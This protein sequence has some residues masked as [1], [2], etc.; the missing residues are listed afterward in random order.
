M[1]RVV[2]YEEVLDE[3]DFE[4]AAA[5]WP[6]YRP[7]KVQESLEFYR[8]R[9]AHNPA[10][11]AQFARM[12]AVSGLVEAQIG[13][14]HML[15]DG[16]GVARDP[17]AAFRWFRIAARIGSAEANNMAGRCC[18]LGWGVGVD[19]A[20][21]ARY[22]RV[23]AAQSHA[24]AQYNLARLIVC[25]DGVPCDYRAALDLL[26]RS[27]RSGN[28]KSMNM[29]GRFREEGWAAAVKLK[30]AA[31]WYRR[32]AERGCFR[33][34][35][36]TSRFL[37]AEGHIAEAAQWLRRSLAGAH[38]EFRHEAF[39]ALSNHPAAEIREAVY[40]YCKPERAS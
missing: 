1:G 4:S 31:R 8:A 34:Q 20:Q 21:A 36:H 5:A 24:W 26:V 15:L 25:G 7:I 38:D 11:A 23:A 14:A 18:E 12:E 40:A 17:A 6:Q 37:C 29:I 33:G 27:A 28:E 10:A 9:L 30:A 35:F 2:S 19:T 16:Y 22:Y 3:D 39:A 13:W 32:A